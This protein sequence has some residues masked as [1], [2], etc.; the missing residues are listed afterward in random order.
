MLRR[1]KSNPSLYAPV[2][3]IALTPVIG[4]AILVSVKVAPGYAD[5]DEHARRV[6]PQ[7]RIQ[8]RSD[9]GR[10]DHRPSEKPYRTIDG[11]G[12]NRDNPDW[13]AA[14]IQ[15]LRFVPSD[16]A[17]GISTLAGLGR[18][19]P[20][21]IS[22]AVVDQPRL[23]IPNPL[24][25]SD[26]LWQWGQFLDHDIDLTEGTD[27]PE[28]ED[29]PIPKNDPV[30]DSGVFEFNRS[31]YDTATGTGAG[32][33]RQQLNE[34]TAFVDAS[35]VY[36]SDEERASALRTKDGTGKLKT[37][38][39]NLLPFNTD[40]LPNAGGSSSTLFVAGDV[41][42]N[43]Q[44]ALTAMHTLFV[45]EHN[46]LAEEIAA[47]DHR[48]SGDEIYERARKIVG[49]Q[50]QV[51]TYREFLPAL[52]GPGSLSRYHGYIPNANPGIGNLFSTAMFRFGHSLLSP[53]LLRLDADG[54]EI[55]KGHL[56]LSDA[57]FAPQLITPEGGIEPLLRGLAAQACQALDPFIVDDVRNF[58]FAN[59]GTG[60]DLA[61]LNIQRGRDHGLPS[62]NDTREAFG[63]RRARSFRDVSSSRYIQKRLASVY[64][65]VDD[66][67]L[68]VGALSEDP[69]PGGHVGALIRATLKRQFEALRDGDR[70]WYEQTFSRHEIE[71]LEN[72]KLSDIIRRNT[73][74]GNE[75]SDNV[76]SVRGAGEHKVV[77][78]H[79]PKYDDRQRDLRKR[80]QRE[81]TNLQHATVRI[82]G[83]VVRPY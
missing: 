39:G 45:R 17:D 63:L 37:S 14:G 7:L 47:A 26:Y 40:G 43:E 54:N 2:A 73:T 19:G 28:P 79:P 3:K 72:T 58:L 10:K 35:N 27:P 29:I 4:L 49:A 31:I 48:L 30:F 21:D 22:N 50:I 44:V 20:R 6:S 53:T 12:N 41:R 60:F 76:F 34:I 52:M 15:L 25:A 61:S 81:L 18:P 56:S 64:K 51:I 24:G 62:Y 70:F 83:S 23:S 80:V 59:V 32:N 9:R 38:E 33:P 1:T 77:R 8:H 69:V 67:D 74:I 71:E 16:Y 11:S 42:A 13:G 46:R 75:I 57:F 55:P 82:L 65:D 36:G 5:S 78:H 66:I 68:W